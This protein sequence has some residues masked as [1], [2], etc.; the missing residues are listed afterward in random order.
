[1]RSKLLA[2]SNPFFLQNCI[3]HVPRC[4]KSWELKS[5]WRLHF[6]NDSFAVFEAKWE[7]VTCSFL[8]MSA[9]KGKRSDVVKWIQA[10]IWT[11]WWM[12]EIFSWKGL[13]EEHVSSDYSANFFVWKNFQDFQGFMQSRKE[14]FYLRSCKQKIIHRI[15]IYST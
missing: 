13:R 4:C 1:M 15:W 5:N 11:F 12:F 10:N 9:K 14:T 7:F 8:W 2:I 3:N 6:W